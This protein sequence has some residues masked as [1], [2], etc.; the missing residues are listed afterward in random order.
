[1]NLKPQELKVDSKRVLKLFLASAFSGF[2]GWNFRPMIAGNAD[3]INTIVTI[4]SILAGFLIAVM[5]FIAEP[6]LR[7]AR[8][9]EDLQSMKKTVKRQ[10]LR[11]KILFFLYLTTLGLALTMYLIPDGCL[12][13]MKWSEILFLSL[14]TFVFLASF[15]LPSSLINVQIERYEAALQDKRPKVLSDAIDRAKDAA[16][17]T[18]S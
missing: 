17:N 1:M 14:A 2:V 16:S 10:L 8:R 15:T 3:A 4:F 7:R 11:Q 18:P 6:V 9:W 13:I 12:V 5:T